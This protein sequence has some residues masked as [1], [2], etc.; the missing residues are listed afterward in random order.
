MISAGSA[1]MVRIAMTAS[2]MFEKVLDV[3]NAHKRFG[4]CEAG[5]SAYGRL[6]R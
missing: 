5:Y 6:K 4:A 2:E 1:R 3:C